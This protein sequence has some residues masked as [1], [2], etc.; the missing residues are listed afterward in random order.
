MQVM[1]GDG[2]INAKKCSCEY[3][4]LDF[5][6][7]KCPYQEA[8]QIPKSDLPAFSDSS[9][10]LVPSDRPPMF[11]LI[12]LNLRNLVMPTGTIKELNSLLSPLLLSG[13]F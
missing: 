10:Q 2:D 7:A 11:A 12:K 3:F 8:A 9:C 4:L 5:T 1:H 6:G 13:T